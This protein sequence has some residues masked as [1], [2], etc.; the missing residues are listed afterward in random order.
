M[1]SKQENGVPKLKVS[2]LS[3]VEMKEQAAMEAL[4]EYLA[5]EIEPFPEKEEEASIKDRKAP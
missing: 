2:Y 5:W 1:D 4:A 3:E